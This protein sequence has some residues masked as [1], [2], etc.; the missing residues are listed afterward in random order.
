MQNVKVTFGTPYTA[1]NDDAHFTPSDGGW[2]SF[3]KYPRQL[4]DING[5]GFEDIVGF[6]QTKVF[7]ALGNANGTFSPVYTALDGSY[8]VDDGGW[9]SFDKYPRQ[10]GDINGDGF[11]D[12]VGFGETLVTAAL[13]KADG[14]FGTPYTAFNDDAHFTPSDGGW[15]SF[16]K[17]PRQLAD[18][19]GDGFEDIVGFGQTKVFAALGNA[20]GTFSPVYTALDGSYTVDDGGW[21]SFDKY[22]RQLGDINGDG[23]ADI[24]GFGETLVTAALGKADGT[25]GTPYTAFN[26]DAH[27]TPSDGGWTS[28]NKYPRKLADI[29]GDGFEDIVGFGQTQVFAALGNANGTFSPVYTALDG[30]YTI[31]DGGWDSFDKY[32]R[33]LGDVNGDGFADIV[34]FGETAVFAALGESELDRPFYR[35]Q[36][37]DRPGTYL[38]VGEEE[39][40][41]ILQNFTQFQEEG[42]AFSVSS[43]PKDDL[44]RFNRFQNQNV[45]GTYLYA[46]EEESINIR[47]NFPNF[48]E[49]GIAF[50][51]YDANAGLGIDFYRFQNTQQP[52]TYIFVGE[53]ERQSIIANFP[54]FVEEGIAFEV[55]L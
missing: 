38:F 39:R 3:N 29:N 14:T 25:F 55:A 53:E 10:L 27:F 18:I 54:Q 6:G 19:N 31:D 13:G 48:N 26:D 5:D 44:I 20:N 35:F 4:A 34:G 30:N 51:A 49:E 41:S 21:D 15:T 42:R 50:Y 23:F 37:S 28:F 7:A 11:A 12:I 43:E 1:F 52:G 24:V 47:Q 9:D 17:Y 2:T 33:Q 16:N 36:N 8:T 32:P 45:P 40:Q 22:P 46:G